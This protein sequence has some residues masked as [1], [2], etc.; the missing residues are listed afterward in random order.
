MASGSKKGP[1]VAAIIM[2]LVA[3]ALALWLASMRRADAAECK[4]LAPTEH[5]HDTLC[6]AAAVY[7][8]A[9]SQ[10]EV[11]QELVA[12]VVINRTHSPRWPHDICAVVW[13][14]QQFA[15]TNGSVCL[16][17][18]MTASDWEAAVQVARRVLNRRDQSPITATYFMN[19]DTASAEARDWFYLNLVPLFGYD[20]AKGNAHHFFRHPDDPA[21][22][23]AMA[24]ELENENEQTE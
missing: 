18:D 24:L 22:L 4:R 21:T 16:S 13:Q 9:R 17:P 19:P 1:S 20:D 8:E 11:G 23:E 2:L 7:Y 6:L 15:W 3:I 12:W 14:P 10:D 5:D